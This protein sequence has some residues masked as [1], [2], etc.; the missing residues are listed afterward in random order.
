MNRTSK[1]KKSNIWDG[2]KYSNG[3]CYKTLVYNYFI[4]TPEMAKS[5][6]DYIYKQQTYEQRIMG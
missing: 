3:L 6:D 5:I 2:W 1:A 4:K